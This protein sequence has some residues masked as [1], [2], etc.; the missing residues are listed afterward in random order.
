M[1]DYSYA[2]C[3]IDPPA[4]SKAVC[5]GCVRDIW[6]WRDSYNAPATAGFWTRALL[7]RGVCPRSRV[8]RLRVVLY[9]VAASYPLHRIPATAEML[10]NFAAREAAIP[11]L[12]VSL[13]VL[14]GIHRAVYRRI[15]ISRAALQGAGS[16]MG[17]LARLGRQCR[18]FRDL[19]SGPGLGRAA[20]HGL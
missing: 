4:K 16:G 14:G 8:G 9:G 18:L 3:F 5:F 1:Y 6:I 11:H 13:F 20:P 12:Q 15:S 17:R 10:R 19:S 2:Q 7:A